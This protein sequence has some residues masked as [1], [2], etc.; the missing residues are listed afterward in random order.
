[1]QMRN[2]ETHIPEEKGDENMNMAESSYTTLD[3]DFILNHGK[4]VSSQEALSEVTPIEWSEDA[5]SGKYKNKTII[6][7]L[8]TGMEG[9]DL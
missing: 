7:S 3:V 5:L 9:K 8:L 4:S 1:M 6:K 2:N